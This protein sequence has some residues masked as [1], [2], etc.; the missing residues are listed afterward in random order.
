MSLSINLKFVTFFCLNRIKFRQKG[1]TRQYK[2]TWRLR[3]KIR[4][5]HSWGKDDGEKGRTWSMR[6]P[7]QGLL[8]IVYELHVTYL[9]TYGPQ[10][11]HN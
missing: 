10:Q 6:P 2:W 11:D 8:Y 1:V 3:N 7:K 9:H 4:H 5:W